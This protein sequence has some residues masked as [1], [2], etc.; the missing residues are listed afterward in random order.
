MRLLYVLLLAFA[1]KGDDAAPAKAPVKQH[2]VQAVVPVEHLPAHF[3]LPASATRKLVRSS[4]KIA[5]TVWE[6]EYRDLDAKAAVKK[7]EDGMTAAKYTVD[8]K[9]DGEVVGSFDG[10]TYAVAA[11]AKDAVTYVTIRSFPQS[12]PVTLPAPS[13]YPAKFPFV[14]GGTAS[15]EAEGSQLRV[16][17]TQDAKDIEA[18]MVF[19][20]K[21]AGWTCTGTGTVTCTREKSSVTFTTEAAPGG[22]LLV[23]SS[24]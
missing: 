10:K 2:E 24:R 8:S 13:S 17:Y 12:G 6:Y 20:A 22:S 3:P 11:S 16:A 15:Y 5:M 4:S 23:V 18:A 14:A 21:A 7:I 19:A 9:S 1:C